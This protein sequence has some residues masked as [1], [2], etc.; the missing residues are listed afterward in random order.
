MAVMGSGIM[1]NSVGHAGSDEVEERIVAFLLVPEFSMLAFTA[2]VEPLRA[3]NELSQNQLYRWVVLSPRGEP[4]A[5]SNGLDISTHGALDSL[6]RCWAA[7]VCGGRNSHL[8]REPLVDSWLRRLRY[9]GAKIGAIS[10]GTYVLARAGLLDGYACTIHWNCIE[11]FAETYPDIEITDSLYKIDRDRFT[12]SGGTASM[13]LMLKLIELDHGRDLAKSV[14]EHFMHIDIRDSQTNQRTPVCARYDLANDKLVAILELMEN[15]LEE[16]FPIA[17]L[18]ELVG[19]STRHMER[20]FAA[21]LKSTPSRYYLELRLQRAKH[22]LTSSRLSVTEIGL[23]CGFTS[24]SHFAKCY[25][26]SY[27]ISPRIERR[28]LR[29]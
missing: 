14:A 24:M 27:G 17:S 21:Y 2:A 9:R 1:A 18:S 3:A 20:L 19:V 12:C 5:C 11:G 13:D 8:K 29:T 25:R 10:D 6:E 15:N 26:V 28:S 7:V 22:L 16:P 4:V 23:A